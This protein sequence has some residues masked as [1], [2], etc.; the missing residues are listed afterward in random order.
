MATNTV[1]FAS[2]NFTNVQLA[3]AKLKLLDMASSVAIVTLI[4]NETAA[5]IAADAAEGATRLAAD[6]AEAATRA[7]ADTNLQNQIDAQSTSFAHSMLLG[8]M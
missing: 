6:N 4:N 5:R 1:D 3:P 7:A 2:W 8:G